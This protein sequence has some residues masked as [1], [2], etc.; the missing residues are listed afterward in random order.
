MSR[1]GC[2]KPPEDAAVIAIDGGGSKTDVWALDL[3]G[4]IVARARGGGSSPQVLGVAPVAQILDALVSEVIDAAG[5]RPVLQT[6][7]YLSGLDLPVEVEAFSA[8]V[9]PFAWSTGVTGRPPVLDNDLFALL[10]LGTRAPNAVAL[11]CGTGIN[12]V[13]VRSDG[14][15]VRFPA[16]GAISGDWGGGWFL[17]ERALWHAARAADGRGPE[18][19]LLSRVPEAL[20][21]S[22]VRE[23]TEALHFDRLAGADL[24]RL[25][26]VVFKAAR[27]G[28]PV[29]EALV[30][31]QAEEIVLMLT[32]TLRRL[33]LLDVEV[34]VV[35]GGGVL[36]AGD[37]RLMA[38]ISAG[39]A[40]SAPSARIQLVR[41]RPI[42]GAAILSLES[43]GRR[44][45]A[46]R[47]FER[48]TSSL[49][50]GSSSGAQ[51]GAGDVRGL[52]AR[53]M[54]GTA[55]DDVAGQPSRERS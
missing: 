46:L 24:S 33:E 42:L 16:L 21:L 10:R 47:L 23:V 41:S 43:V 26:P 40:T 48:A 15:Q 45:A 52:T 32:V 54:A 5:W 29:A 39:L 11:V 14:E 19:V 12:C 7:I 6:C 27:E 50:V 3:D 44:G 13:G 37:P 55:D 2:A 18:T 8:A 22:S 51:D 20:G 36:A 25:S 28:D 4:N 1:D 35:L 49:V 17:G 31:R 34:P 9:A 38:A 30:D 53:S